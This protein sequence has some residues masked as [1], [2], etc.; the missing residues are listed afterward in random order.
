MDA[1]AGVQFMVW[2]VGVHGSASH[3]TKASHV[4]TQRS[5]NCSFKLW[6]LVYSCALKH[7]QLWWLAVVSLQVCGA[8][9]CKL[10]H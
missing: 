1:T 3:A 4:T 8:S 10:M 7:V 2:L 5:I 9:A 6:V